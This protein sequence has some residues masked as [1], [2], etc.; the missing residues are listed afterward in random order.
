VGDVAALPPAYLRRF[1]GD[2]LRLHDV[3]RGA[4]GL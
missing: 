3:A 4:Y 1:G 2:A